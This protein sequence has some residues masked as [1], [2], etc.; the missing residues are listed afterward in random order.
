M[1]EIDYEKLR[2]DS[3]IMM[4]NILDGAGWIGRGSD[5]KQIYYNCHHFLNLKMIHKLEQIIVEFF[6]ID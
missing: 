2:N 5:C 1:N 6:N 3:N 4:I